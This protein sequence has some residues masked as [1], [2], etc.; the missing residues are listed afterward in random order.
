VRIT[1]LGVWLAKGF[2]LRSRGLQRALAALAEDLSSIP[3]TGTAA[4]HH[5]S[6]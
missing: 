5:L 4:H 2:N 1:D 6:L 3:S